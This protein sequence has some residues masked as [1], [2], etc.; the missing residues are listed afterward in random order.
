M[1]RYVIVK[2]DAKQADAIF[3]AKVNWL[4]SKRPISFLSRVLLYDPKSK[5]VLGEAIAICAVT[6]HYMQAL[7][8]IKRIGGSTGLTEAQ[9]GKLAGKS[10]TITANM[11]CRPQRYGTPIDF[12]DGTADAILAN[13]E[14]R[15]I[16]LPKTGDKSN[17][18]NN[19]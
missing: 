9:L 11:V 12:T 6:S 19:H 16:Q 10:E 18:Q 15:A 4:C 5:T 1:S 17:D 3:S 2:S 14:W 8:I 13:S 7:R